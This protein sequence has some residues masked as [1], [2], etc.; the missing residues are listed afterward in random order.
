MRVDVLTM[1]TILLALGL[2]ASLAAR[3][4]AAPPPAV[5]FGS[6]HDH[7]AEGGD[8]G[9][10][11][12]AEALAAARA[13]GFQFFGVSPHNHMI[14][15]EHFARFCEA[16]RSAEVPGQFLPLAAFEW[17]AISKGGHVGVVG[18]DELITAQPTD[19]DGFWQ[20]AKADKG[21]PMLVLNHPV[22]GRRYGGP[23]DEERIR[24]APLM[25]VLGG[26]GEYEGPDLAG[27]CE[28]SHR[29][30]ALSLNAGWRCGVAYGEDNHTGTWGRVNRT[31]M[32]VYAAS[33]SREALMQAFRA[34]RTFVTED[35]GMR[36]WIECGAVPMGGEAP[37]D[38]APLSVFVVH[39]SEAIT[40][41]AVYV[42]PDGPGGRVADEV[43]RSSSGTFTVTVKPVAAGACAFVVA[44]D[45]SKDLAWSSPI[46]F[47]RP[48]AVRP[49][50]DVIE[51]IDL[52]FASPAD[53]D[54]VQGFGR[55]TVKQIMTARRSGTIFHTVDELAT[56]LPRELVDRVAAQVK[57]STPEET[58]SAL[59]EGLSSER[60][61]VVTGARANS[62]HYQRERAETLLAWQLL[63][64]AQAGHTDHAKSVLASLEGTRAGLSESV[65]NVW[66]IAKKLALDSG[67]AAAVAAL[68]A[69]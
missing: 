55:G 9:K 3:V 25:E 24:R 40:D 64:L 67:R 58:V 42:D 62:A 51:R 39:A 5:Y 49:A 65:R 53:L 36:V 31:R 50:V 23:P 10:G 22:W 18:A 54:R 11:S 30:Y 21:D 46:W 38:S 29:E 12:L 61:L 2:A 41:V 27:R 57:I 37:L 13:A 59:Y 43:E 52:N 4:P 34:R 15:R 16:V 20:S 32:G 45:A 44:R 19:W 56:V 26:P 47:G 69:N 1:R 7:T 17:G 60:S 68:E 28:F 6:L 48:T 33:L 35:P 66:R 14:S 8:D 63:E